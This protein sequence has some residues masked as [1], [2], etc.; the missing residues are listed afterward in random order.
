MTPPSGRRSRG[1]ARRQPTVTTG[2][3]L[4]RRQALSPFRRPVRRRKCRQKSHP[5]GTLTAYEPRSGERTGQGGK[6]LKS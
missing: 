6:V 5:Y 3:A 2:A 1:G 4:H